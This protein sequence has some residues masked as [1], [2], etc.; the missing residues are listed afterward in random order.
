MH[1]VISQRM[2]RRTCSNES[3][4]FT[5]SPW[6]A[7]L[8]GNFTGVSRERLPTLVTCLDHSCASDSTHYSDSP[9]WTSANV[10]MGSTLSPAAPSTDCWGEPQRITSFVSPISRQS[11]C[12][13]AYT[14]MARQLSRLWDTTA[15]DKL[16]VSKVTIS[17]A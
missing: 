16:S 7:P 11:E 1:C 3:L 4:P 17:Y 14:A 13:S 9:L 6:T 12:W 8:S 5:T 2:A 15:C 10:R